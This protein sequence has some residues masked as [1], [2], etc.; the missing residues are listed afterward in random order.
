METN[1]KL[2]QDSKTINNV[3]AELVKNKI[4]MS[5]RRIKQIYQNENNEIEKLEE[6]MVK[7]SEKLIPL[8]EER[9]VL[10]NELSGIYDSYLRYCKETGLKVVFEGEN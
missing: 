4:E 1:I 5:Y 3:T 7:L 6:K 2:N 9:A 8:K 10:E